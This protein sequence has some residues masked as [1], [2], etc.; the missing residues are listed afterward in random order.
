M[1]AV[2]MGCFLSC[3]HAYHSVSTPPV[4]PQKN[5][6]DVKLQT[7]PTSI[8][9]SDAVIIHPGAMLAMLDLLASV[10]SATHPEVGKNFT[11]LSFESDCEKGWLWEIGKLMMFSCFF[12]EKLVCFTDQKS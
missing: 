12:A 4:C 7:G 8:Q 1:G 11:V 6:A 3:R 9:S 10:G 2:T 5:I